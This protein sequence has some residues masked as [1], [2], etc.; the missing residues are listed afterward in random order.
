[1]CE[2]D[3]DIS[4][5][6][7]G[8]YFLIPVRS[9]LHPK[10][11]AA[12]WCAEHPELERRHCLAEASKAIEEVCTLVF[13]APDSPSEAATAP[14]CGRF[15]SCSH[16]FA[17]PSLT[18]AA[19]VMDDESC[20]ELHSAFHAAVTVSASPPSARFPLRR[21]GSPLQLLPAFAGHAN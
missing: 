21:W 11:L 19:A 2:K 6:I 5:I 10:D 13:R 12:G 7:L 20:P 3:I 16:T 4:A 1:L 8:T 14:G 15:Q 9:V 17:L 18:P